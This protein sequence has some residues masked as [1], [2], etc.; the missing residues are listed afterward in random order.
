MRE[1]TLIQMATPSRWAVGHSLAALS[2]TC[3]GTYVASVYLQGAASESDAVAW[4]GRVLLS[5]IPTAMGMAAILA[6][7]LR[8]DAR[9]HRRPHSWVV[10]T[11]VLSW[12][13]MGLALF[14]YLFLTRLGHVRWVAIAQFALLLVL[15]LQAQTLGLALSTH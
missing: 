15:L 5:T 8:V 2:C 9:R 14:G 3:A 6:S 13:S 10:A 7:W 1:P 4:M 12:P 11:T